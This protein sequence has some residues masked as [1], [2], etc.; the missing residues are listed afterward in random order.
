METR[1]NWKKN[2]SGWLWLMKFQVKKEEK[3]TNERVEKSNY[4]ILSIS[5]FLDSSSTVK[6]EILSNFFISVS[7]LIK[8]FALFDSWNLIFRAIEFIKIDRCRACGHSEEC[9]KF[10]YKMFCLS[11][12]F[13]YYQMN[14]MYTIYSLE[15][16]SLSSIAR[17]MSTGEFL[18]KFL[19]TWNDKPISLMMT[20]GLNNF[21]LFTDIPAILY[22]Q[23]VA[24]LPLHKHKYVCAEETFSTID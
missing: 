5:R 16:G 13:L 24:L 11:F 9:Q 6:S 8:T 14:I 1:Y 22:E 3:I 23:C 20:N 18:I 19:F 7:N 15:F 2:F 12:L 4:Q 10:L 17:W 21:G